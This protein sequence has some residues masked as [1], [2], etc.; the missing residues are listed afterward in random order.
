MEGRGGGMG[1]HSRLYFVKITLA[2]K[3][4]GLAP[5][6]A[7]NFPLKITP[8][9]RHWNPGLRLVNRDVRGYLKDKSKLSVH[10]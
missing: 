6:Q 4:L 10:L 8:K 5:N 7:C 1:D 2:P 9:S 3:T